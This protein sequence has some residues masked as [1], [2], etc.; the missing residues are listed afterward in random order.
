MHSISS[1]WIVFFIVFPH[2]SIY[3]FTLDSIQPLFR[4]WQYAVVVISIFLVFK[5]LKT[6]NLLLILYTLVLAMSAILNGNL[7]PPV[8]FSIGVLLGFAIYLNHAAR[9]NF[10]ELITGLYYLF[11]LVIVINFFTMIVTHGVAHGMLG[12]P[13]YFLGNK[14]AIALTAIPAVAL[15]YLYSHTVHKKTKFIPLAVSIIAALSCYLST[16]G[17]GV[18]ASMMIA[19]FILLPKKA[20]PS[21]KTLILTYI[22]IFFTV[23]VF[24]LHEVLFGNFIVNVLHKDITLTGRTYIWDFVLSNVQQSWFLGFGMGQRMIIDYFNTG[25]D[26][27][28]NGILEVLMFSGYLG[29]FLFASVLLLVG[30]K[31]MINKNSVVNVTLSYSVFSFLIVGISESV[32]HEME[33]WLL[34]VISYNVI[35]EIKQVDSVELPVLTEKRLTYI[36]PSFNNVSFRQV[37]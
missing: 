4:I 31:L 9:T 1:R 37:E 3:Y 25:F 24:R 6:F 14:N 7:I 19:V 8:L 28:H 20:I 11:G 33:F 5:N 30:R 26:V 23:V 17:T 29:L 2:L 35:S 34:L 18:V 21:F 22:S 10:N 27:A 12:E 15:A 32:F 36:K 16:S 13:I